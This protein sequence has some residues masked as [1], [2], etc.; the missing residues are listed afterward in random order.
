MSVLFGSYKVI[1][2]VRVPLLELL[3]FVLPTNMGVAKK[4]LTL[5]ARNAELEKGERLY[6][7]LKLEASVVD[8]EGF[9]FFQN[10]ENLNSCIVRFYNFWSAK[11]VQDYWFYDFLKH[12]HLTQYRLNFFS[13]FGPK[14]MVKI[15]NDAPRIFFSGENVYLSHLKYQDYCLDDVDL[16]MGYEYIDSPN[17]LRLPLWLLLAFPPSA[18]YECVKKIIGDLNDSSLRLNGRCKF[19]SLIASHNKS[20]G[21]GRVKMRNRFNQIS[22]VECAGKLLRNTNDLQEKFNNDKLAYLKQFKFNLCPENSARHGYVTEKLINS[23]Q[24]GCIP[25]YWGDDNPEPEILNHDAII[26]YNPNDSKI[27]LDK[28]AE[29]WHNQKLYEEF[30]HIPPFKPDAADKIWETLQEL[31]RRVRVL[32]KCK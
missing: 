21:V 16:S 18:D 11:H 10:L 8:G 22:H 31:E 17:Y 9:V 28:V 27:A 2:V 12:R 4:L 6:K 32:T 1:D 29:L 23:I 5:Y 26:F 24:A 3:H 25:I 20:K 7:S 30:C 14:Q 15:K 19:A 13:V